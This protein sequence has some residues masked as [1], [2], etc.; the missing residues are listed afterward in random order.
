ML[1]LMPFQS[2]QFPSLFGLK[3]LGSG[4]WSLSGQV[5][6]DDDSAPQVLTRVYGE[7]VFR[8][9]LG[10]ER[11]RSAQSG[12]VLL[13]VLVRLRSADGTLGARFSPRLA[14][15]LFAGLRTGVREIDFVG[16]FN[17]GRAAGAV[18]MQGAVTPDGETWRQ[19]A[20]RLSASINA[21]IPPEDAGRVSVRVCALGGGRE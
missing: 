20:G 15:S 9:L 18:L 11:K 5:R 17:E 13:L 10:L 16:W 3:S 19:I 21:H 6:A 12:R 8:H 14:D 1:R 2:L 7:D 4:G